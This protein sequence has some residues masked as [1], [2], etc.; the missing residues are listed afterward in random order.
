M[1]KF[2]RLTESVEAVRAFVMNGDGNPIVKAKCAAVAVFVL[3]RERDTR[4]WKKMC[5]LPQPIESYVSDSRNICACL[6]TGGFASIGKLPALFGW[7]IWYGIGI[8]VGLTNAAN[9]IRSPY[10]K[11][12]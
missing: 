7:Y 1:K 5:A 9:S 6:F 11:G 8:K 12:I 2:L 4:D 3:L 10:L